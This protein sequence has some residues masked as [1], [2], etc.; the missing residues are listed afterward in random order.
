VAKKK[1]RGGYLAGV[2]KVA[3]AIF[4]GVALVVGGAAISHGLIRST[5][6]T[7]GDGVWQEYPRRLV[8]H[9]TGF[10]PQS[11]KIDSG[12]A[13]QSIGMI[14]AGVVAMALIRFGAKRL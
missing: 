14:L 5:V 3:K 8:V 9:Y 11:G 10:D 4:G 13:F 1:R 7:I 12:K 6:D 2:R